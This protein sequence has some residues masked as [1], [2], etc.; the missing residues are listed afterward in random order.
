MWAAGIIG[1]S[2]DELKR[3]TKRAL[4]IDIEITKLSEFLDYMLS[5]IIHTSEEVQINKPDGVSIIQEDLDWIW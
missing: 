4:Y 5:I 1:S 2:C 3:I